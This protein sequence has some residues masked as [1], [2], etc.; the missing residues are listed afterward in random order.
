[1]STAINKNR[2]LALL[3]ALATTELDR[4]RQRAIEDLL[5]GPLDWE[6]LLS[7]AVQHG[8][9][10]LLFHH[11]HRIAS[12]LAPSDIMQ[13]L[14]ADCMSIAARNLILA[15]NLKIISAHLRSRKIEHIVYKGPLLAE[16][17]FGNCALRVSHDL[18]IFVPPSELAVTRDALGEI[19]FRDKYGLNRA[20]QAMSFRFG[21]EHSFTAA[22]GIDL[23][24]HWRVVQKFKS[25]SLDMEGIW[26]RAT[27]A[28]AWDCDLPTFCPEDLLVALCLHAG[29]HGWMQL[30]HICDI[31]QLLKRYPNL[32]WNI[33]RRHLGDSNTTR[34][35]YVSLNLL[36]QH[37]EAE[38]P[39]DLI[40]AML[41]DPHVGRLTRRIQTEIW[42][43][44]KPALTTS[45]FRWLMDRS[46]GVNLVDRMRLFTGTLFCPA[47]EDFEM[48]RLPEIFAPLYPGLRA[49][50]LAF[51][52][53][54]S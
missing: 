39:G 53:T 40:D 52:Y 50:R 46:S 18:D 7:M 29:H 51:K 37:W 22:G 43:S 5:A 9:E 25:S 49:L 28:R 3:I 31:A 19:G 27:P 32:D 16:T 11:L 21:F 36:Q 4:S 24:L 17:Y 12:H 38:I 48:F 1:M 54:V 35:V 41:A 44:S 47:S 23:D 30:S 26:Q 10:P 13:A 2:E 15:S 6:C 20:Q 8:L 34:M 14:R 33:V 42:P 45:S